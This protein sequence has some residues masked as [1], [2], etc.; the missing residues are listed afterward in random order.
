MVEK[1][2]QTI[3]ILTFDQSKSNI[4]VYQ[5]SILHFYV[6]SPVV[7]LI[8]CEQDKENDKL[9]YCFPKNHLCALNLRTII[10][11]HCC[12]LPICDLGTGHKVASVG[13]GNG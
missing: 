2:A 10:S 3:D 7:C 12:N 4:I 9:K 13:P 1:K 8:V 5:F 6:H 11:S